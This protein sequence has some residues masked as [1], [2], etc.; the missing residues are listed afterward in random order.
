MDFLL[1]LS[2]LCADALEKGAIPHW[3]YWLPRGEAQRQPGCGEVSNFKKPSRADQQSRSAP[4]LFI[5]K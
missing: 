4:A 1:A 3:K 5:L 2:D